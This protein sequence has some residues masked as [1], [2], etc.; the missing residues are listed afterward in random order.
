MGSIDIIKELTCGFNYPRYDEGGDK[1]ISAY[2]AL[3]HDEGKEL[4]KYAIKLKDEKTRWVILK[5]LNFLVPGSL[6][7]LHMEILESDLID[8]PEFFINASDVV[9]HQVIRKLEQ[10]TDPNQKINLIYILAWIGSTK[11]QREL[12]ELAQT[13]I[14]LTWGTVKI[15]DLIPVAGWELTGDGKRRDLFY[16]KSYCLDFVETK[17]LEFLTEKC[18]WCKRSLFVPFDF[19]LLDSQ[20]KF[21]EFQGTTLRIPTCINCVEYSPIF[22]RFDMQGLCQ[23]SHLNIKPDHLRTAPENEIE[24]SWYPPKFQIGLQKRSPYEQS[25]WLPTSFGQ[26][27]GFPGWVQSPEFPVCPKCQRRMIFLAQF[28]VSLVYYAFICI[29]CKIAATVTQAD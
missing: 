3:S 21:L 1:L 4:A 12:R 5:N 26:I 25:A 14:E 10:T 8:S 11:A 6:L 15:K 7:D 29:D 27:G 17:R 24:E 16:S 18:P 28:D 19:N 23:W 2:Y 13:S 20:I 9:C 22:I